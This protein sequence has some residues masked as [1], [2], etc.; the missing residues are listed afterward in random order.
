MAATIAASALAVAPLPYA[1][2]NQNKILEALACAV[3]VVAT[4]AAVGDLGLIHGESVLIADSVP[5]FVDHIVRLLRDPRFAD[6]IGNAG[7]AYVIKNHSISSAV[8]SLEKLYVSITSADGAGRP[9]VA[10]AVT[11]C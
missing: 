2:G 8:D 4:S 5:E 11:R 7:R 3:P 9:V 6:Q 1:V 10:Q